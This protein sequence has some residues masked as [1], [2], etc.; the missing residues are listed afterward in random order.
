MISFLMAVSAVVLFSGVSM[1]K[2]ELLQQHVSPELQEAL[3][4]AGVF[5]EWRNL[6]QKQQEVHARWF[7]NTESFLDQNLLHESVV[8]FRWESGVAKTVPDTDVVTTLIN[9]NRSPTLIDQMYRVY[10][11]PPISSDAMYEGKEKLMRSYETFMVER[12]FRESVFRAVLRVMD[13]LDPRLKTIYEDGYRSLPVRREAFFSIADSA[14][15]Q[16]AVKVSSQRQGSLIGWGVEASYVANQGFVDHESD[17]LITQSSALD[18]AL[19]SKNTS[20]RSAAVFA[21]SDEKMLQEL[22]RLPENL[23][24]ARVRSLYIKGRLGPGH[25]HV[26]CGNGEVKRIAKERLEYLSYQ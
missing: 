10:A 11:A 25:E 8:R 20:M 9:D 6:Q 18:L 22:V 15:V 1:A 23:C 14:Y 17:R 21:I 5:D 3:E 26:H 7:L 19:Y 16:R 12:R 24:P 13:G 2:D 4:Q